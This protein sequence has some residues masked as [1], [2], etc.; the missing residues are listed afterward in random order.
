MGVLPHFGDVN[1]MI[2]IAALMSA[3]SLVGLGFVVVSVPAA[4]A[5]CPDGIVEINCYTEN[6]DGS[7]ANWCAIYSNL[8]GCYGHACYWGPLHN[9]P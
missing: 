5:S 3:L 9:C 6:P 2:R 7:P 1:T 4:S 8:L